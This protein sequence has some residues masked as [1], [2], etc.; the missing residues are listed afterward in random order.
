MV[1][2]LENI[3]AD[4]GWWAILFSITL[5]SVIN[6]I[7]FV[8]SVFVTGANV[9]VWGPWLGGLI[10]WLGEVIGSAAAFFLYR[11]GVQKVRI[12]RHQDWK[13]VKTLNQMTRLRQILSLILARIAP[14]VPSGVVNIASAFT[15]V[16][17]S[18]FLLATAIGKIPSISI[19]V[20]VS[21]DLI[22][23]EENYIRL[24]I[25]LFVL[26]TGLLL[27]QKNKI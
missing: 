7:G 2:N 1:I 10:S 26:V 22:H 4:W 13:W 18:S 23:V 6:V 5:N 11:L 16:S 15:T 3:F 8:P 20:I 24:G 17:F 19:E 25:T 9:I 12:K 21:Y 14:F 27:W